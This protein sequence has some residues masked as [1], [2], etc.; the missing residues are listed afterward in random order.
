ML[1]IAHRINTIIQS[2]KVLVLS[3]GQLMEFDSPQALMADPNSEFS[4]LIK[5]FKK[6]QH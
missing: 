1:V 3:Q 6:E 2:D 5:D 4:Q